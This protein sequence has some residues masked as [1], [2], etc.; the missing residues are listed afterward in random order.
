[1]IHYPSNSTDDL[2]DFEVLPTE[3]IALDPNS[4]DTAVQLC[5]QIANEAQ[6]WQ[7]YLNALALLGF[8]QWLSERAADI[9]VERENCSVLQPQYANVIDAV[10]NLK[11]G[12]FKLC[13]LATGTTITPV[14][15]V[16]KAV[17]DIPE[18]TAHFYVV[19]E[20]Q[21]E[22]EQVT[23]R[24]FLRYDELVN[25]RPSVNLQADLDWIYE[26]PL[27]WFNSDLDCLL[28]YLRCLEG[29]AIVMPSVPTNAIASLSD[30]QAELIQ[31][32]VNVG[33][34]LRDELDDFTQSLSWILLPAPA[35]A[36]TSLR[37]LSVLAGESPSEEF[38]AIIAGLK[39]TGMEIPPDA[40]GAYRDLTLA[41]LG[42][43]LY[44]LTWSLV[45]QGNT[46]EWSLLLVLGAQPGTAL[47]HG[48]KLQVSEQTNVLIERVL[49][50]NDTHLYTRV[51][52]TWD[53]K[54]VVTVAL[55]NGEALT[56][57]P[58]AFVPES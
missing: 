13:L 48:I 27:S 41:D 42:L 36:T 15:N 56:L 57:P 25:L 47:P 58:F 54:F 26:L 4:I 16:P 10:C 6:Q 19:L 39:A 5:S 12:K 38:E 32:V 22:Q 14:V 46:P 40:R 45:S 18:Y 8:E 17:I 37:S 11:V 31:R 55:M 35:L 30:M 50:Q 29:A 2:F 1:M 21:E 9:P 7:T 20:V 24:G 49:E 51:V 34:W 53:E 23:L 3:A 33:L 52:G 43:R 28:L 44:A